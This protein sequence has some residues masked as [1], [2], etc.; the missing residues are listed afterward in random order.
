MISEMVR[1][2]SLSALMQVPEHIFAKEVIKMSFLSV[3]GVSS[4]LKTKAE[5]KIIQVESCSRVPS[6]T[7]AGN[8][9]NDSVLAG[10]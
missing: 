9:I 4:L 5:R 8:T 2:L 3:W 10:S 7:R 6:P 1:M